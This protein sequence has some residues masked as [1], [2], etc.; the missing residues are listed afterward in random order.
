MG[1]QA[2]TATA[3]WTTFAVSVSEL[4]LARTCTKFARACGANWQ[5]WQVMFRLQIRDESI[6]RPFGAQSGFS[7][8]QDLCASG[9]ASLTANYFL[10]KLL[11]RRLLYCCTV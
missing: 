8:L 4:V 6:K 7:G 1:M 9:L 2:A 10:E 5:G 11:V 3:A